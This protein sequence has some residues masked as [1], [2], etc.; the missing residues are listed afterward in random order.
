LIFTAATVD[1]RTRMCVSMA[2]FVLLRFLG[3]IKKHCSAT[4]DACYFK[5]LTFT[6]HT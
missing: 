3:N 5:D 2:T 1:L 6:S 4:L